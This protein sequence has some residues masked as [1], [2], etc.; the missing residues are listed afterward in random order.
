MAQRV[1]VALK[2]CL[3]LSFAKFLCACTLESVNNLDTGSLRGSEQGGESG[4]HSLGLGQELLYGYN[5]TAYVM[6]WWIT[7]GSWLY[8]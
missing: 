6:A 1:I 7:V 4:S 8:Y 2:T 3:P 5:L